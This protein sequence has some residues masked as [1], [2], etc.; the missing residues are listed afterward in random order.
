MAQ[1]TTKQED[2]KPKETKQKAKPRRGRS[3]PNPTIQLII[4][5][6][7]LICIALILVELYNNVSVAV[8]G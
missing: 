2:S 4:L 1:D 6:V 8:V 5:G 3:K 7:V